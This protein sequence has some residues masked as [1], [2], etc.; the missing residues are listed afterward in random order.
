MVPSLRESHDRN[1]NKPRRN[2][3]YW[4][5]HWLMLSQLFYIPTCQGND[6]THSGLGSF[7]PPRHTHCQWTQFTI[8]M[9]TGQS[10]QCCSSIKIPSSQVI[11]HCKVAA[12]DPVITCMHGGNILRSRMWWGRGPKRVTVWIWSK[13]I[14]IMYEYKGAGKRLGKVNVLQTRRLEFDAQNTLKTQGGVAWSCN[15]STGKVEIGGSLEPT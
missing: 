14:I 11:L 9:T 10:D 1:W 15:S 2:T 7:P 13:Y 4:P 12:R 6:A 3:D 8:D 5:I